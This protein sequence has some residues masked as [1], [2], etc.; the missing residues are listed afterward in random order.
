MFLS[1]SLSLSSLKS[2]LSLC[3][4]ESSNHTGPH[5]PPTITTQPPQPSHE[6]HI[7]THQPPYHCSPTTTPSFT[8]HRQQTKKPPTTTTHCHTNHNP[9]I[10]NLTTKTQP[11]CQ[12]IVTQIATQNQSTTTTTKN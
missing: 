10:H 3:N 11:Y 6:N 1:I 12:S 7:K 9:S 4:L 2:H 8:N 5:P